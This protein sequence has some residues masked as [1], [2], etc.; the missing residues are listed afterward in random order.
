MIKQLYDPMNQPVSY[1]VA[2]GLVPQLRELVI[3]ESTSEDFKRFSKPSREPELNK[4]DIERILHP[5]RHPDFSKPSRKD[6][7]K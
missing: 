1:A 4:I 6:L 7:I 5:E 3:P 2:Y